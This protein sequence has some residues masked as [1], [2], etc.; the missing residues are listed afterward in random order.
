MKR[1]LVARW[2]VLPL[3]TSVLFQNI[4]LHSVEFASVSGTEKKKSPFKTL[5]VGLDKGTRGAYGSRLRGWDL[6][7]PETS[8]IHLEKLQCVALSPHLCMQSFN[9]SVALFSEWQNLEATFAQ[10]SYQENTQ[11][12]KEFEPQNSVET[13]VVLSQQDGILVLNVAKD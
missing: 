2:F 6:E 4:W 9:N 8:L 13:A 10:K 12:K 11:R 3:E 7:P 1:R 5:F